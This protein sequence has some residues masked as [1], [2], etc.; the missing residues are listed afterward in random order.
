MTRHTRYTLA[1]AALLV[2][3]VI[4]LAAMR[5]RCTC[6]LGGA[7]FFDPATDPREDCAVHGKD[8]TP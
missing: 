6:T 7:D 8:V 1:L 2:G 5:P 3:A 4:F